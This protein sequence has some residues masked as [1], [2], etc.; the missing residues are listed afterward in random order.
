MWAKNIHHKLARTGQSA[1]QCSLKM[2]EA[3]EIVTLRRLRA[4]YFSTDF[5]LLNVQIV[6]LKKLLNAF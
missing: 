4:K 6:Y 1:S 5:T 3:E 2:S